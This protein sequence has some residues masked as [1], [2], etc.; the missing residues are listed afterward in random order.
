[1]EKCCS[2]LNDPAPRG[3]SPCGEGS[4]SEAPS[5]ALLVGID[6]AK[7]SFTAARWVAEEKRP[8][9]L[10]E[11][12]AN[13]PV[14][15]EA[16]AEWLST[17]R[18]KTKRAAVSDAIVAIEQ[19]GSCSE[20]LALWLH[21][22]GYAVHMIAPHAVWKAFCGEAKT[23]AIDSLR[24][25]EYADRYRDRLRP[26]TPPVEVVA[27]LRALLT[28]RE[29]L[30]EHKT[31]LKNI[32]AE[33]SARSTCA[34]VAE[35]VV[36]QT[37]AHLEEQVRRLEAAMQ[38]EIATDAELAQHVDH[39]RSAPGVGLLLAAT[40]LVVTEG[41]TRRLRPRVL[42]AYLGIAPHPYQSGTSVRRRDRSRGYGPP[43]ARRLLHLMA[44][45]LRTHHTQTKAYFL[46]K[47]AE[48]K[49]PRLV[50]NNIANKH[51]RVLCA[52]LRNGQPYI[53]GHRSI[54]PRLMQR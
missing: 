26:Y 16:F 37:I 44:R 17:G 33:F 39:L 30:V 38:E 2:K 49:P 42:A 22:R 20:R 29:R 36:G 27:H 6:P 25:A 11:T 14:G 7:D 13:D 8:S 47:K 32:R 48:G 45:S 9:G 21:G 24:I 41:F 43:I 12:F 10:P 54:N 23:D 53:A 4:H 52:L 40:L 5:G 46:R 28:L 15:Y 1:M 34:A 31:A 50:L 18:S 19:T 3:K 51:L 35:E